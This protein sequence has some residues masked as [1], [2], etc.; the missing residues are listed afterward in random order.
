[1][2][3]GLIL[4]VLGAT[5]S[6]LVHTDSVRAWPSP[7]EVAQFQRY[8]PLIEALVESGLRLVD[9]ADPLARAEACVEL[10]D[11]YAA[12]LREAARQGDMGRAV[13][14]GR[15]LHELLAQGVAVNLRA[16]RR[17]IPLGSTAEH[18]LRD[19]GG[20]ALALVHTLDAALRTV[21]DG[22]RAEDV[23]VALDELVRRHAVLEK[24]FRPA[25]AQTQH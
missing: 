25:T 15:H 11:Q 22:V 8:Q 20:K 19:V 17:D 10:A 24:S 14:V 16:A 13:E 7:E 9:E 1:M 2:T 12:E 6:V 3:R 21:A 5:L 23:R 4:L 18:K